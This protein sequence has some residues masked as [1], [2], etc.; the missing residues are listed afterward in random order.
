MF[1]LFNCIY[2][3]IFNTS[4]PL[5]AADAAQLDST[6]DFL[7]SIRDKSDEDIRKFVVGAF[8]SSSL[9]GGSARSSPDAV[10]YYIGAMRWMSNELKQNME[11]TKTDITETRKHIADSLRQHGGSPAAASSVSQG[12]DGWEDDEDQLK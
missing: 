11:E 9:S 1:L 12:V 2:C 8:E 7:S 10:S 6:S 5:I 3:L 4:I